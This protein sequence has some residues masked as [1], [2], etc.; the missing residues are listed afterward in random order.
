MKVCVFVHHSEEDCEYGWTRELAFWRFE[1][2]TSLLVRY[3]AL[4]LQ[5]RY[6]RGVAS[7]VYISRY[8][9]EDEE[10]G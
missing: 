7:V 4:L 10:V 9:L 3:P 6:L 5:G 1:S 2:L 8:R